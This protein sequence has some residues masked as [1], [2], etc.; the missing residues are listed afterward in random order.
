MCVLV[1]GFCC[2]MGFEVPSVTLGSTGLP[3]LEIM[4][5]D[6][7]CH[8]GSWCSLDRLRSPRLQVRHGNLCNSSVL[9]SIESAVFVIDS[10][11]HPGL[12]GMTSSRRLFEHNPLGTVNILEVCKP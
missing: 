4:G 11:V 5:I 12:H 10:S 2:F 8:L 7:L 3:A 6:N 1:T 9:E